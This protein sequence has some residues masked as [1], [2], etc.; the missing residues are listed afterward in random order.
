MDDEIPPGPCVECDGSGFLNDE[1][2]D[3]CTECE[4]TGEEC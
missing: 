2:T 4:G 1:M 3:I